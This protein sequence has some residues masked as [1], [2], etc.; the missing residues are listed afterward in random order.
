MPAP[1]RKRIAGERPPEGGWL[2]P[3]STGWADLRE[4]DAPGHLRPSKGIAKLK[5]P[6]S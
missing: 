5:R 2:G 6:Q 4:I 1:D 3:C